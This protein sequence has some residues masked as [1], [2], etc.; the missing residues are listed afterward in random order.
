MSVTTEPRQALFRI[1]MLWTDSRYRST[2]LQTIALI[3]V[4]LVIFYLVNNVAQNLANLGKEF[5]F[6]FMSGPSS[7]DI[8]QRLIEY[9]SRSS[10]STA[11]VVGLLNTLL[12]AVMGCILATFLG[13]T[14][15]VLR[16][17]HNW[18]VSRLMTVYIEGVRNVPVLIQILLLSAILDETLP[19]PKQA[20]ALLGGFIVPTNRGF[21]FPIPT[22]QDGS[23]VVVLAFIASVIG[24]IWFGRWATRRQQETGEHLPEFWIKFGLVVGVHVADR[25]R[26]R[27]VLG[28]VQILR[29]QR[30]DDHPQRLG[31]DDQ[32]HGPVWPE[33]QRERRLGLALGHRL[34]TGPHIFGDKGAGV[35]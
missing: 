32:I 31:Q 12:V 4:M 13:V 33:A 29:D 10:H 27:R 28:Q 9:T 6:G 21:Y 24:A 16:L 25:Q 14:A 8:N 23:L 22:F 3:G 2:F 30:R 1:D 20:E 35:D 15:G 11:A 34:D 18:I 26:Q 17:S 5:G 7:Y 19:S